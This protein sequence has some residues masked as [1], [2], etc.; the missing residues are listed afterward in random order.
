MSDRVVWVGVQ[1]EVAEKTDKLNGLKNKAAA[2]KAKN[3]KLDKRCVVTAGTSSSHLSTQSAASG[4]QPQPCNGNTLFT[5]A[6]PVQ[7]RQL[8]CVALLV[9]A[10]TADR[11]GQGF[12]L[13]AGV[14]GVFAA[15]GVLML[16]LSSKP[17]SKAGRV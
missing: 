3:D 8:S 11:S 2:L 17:A 16:A 7:S 9:L 6:L 1:A 14:A 10:L 4:A 15:A 13:A 5:L 12:G